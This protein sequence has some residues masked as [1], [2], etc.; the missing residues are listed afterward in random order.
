M[1]DLRQ[2]LDRI[3]VEK[4]SYVLRH[5]P[6]DF[7]K[8]KEFDRLYSLLTDIFFLEAKTQAVSVFDL[9]TDSTGALEVI[10][11]DHPHHKILRLL[12]EA[13][14]RDIHF[15][16][17]HANDYSQ[18]LFQCLWNSCWWYDYQEAV[19]HYEKSKAR[20]SRN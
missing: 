8:L 3:T 10:S 5:L 14:R 2:Q 19:E 16:A 7:V 17:R 1:S 12:D 13:I 15:I 20:W 9:A 4:R 11:D 18:A 6:D